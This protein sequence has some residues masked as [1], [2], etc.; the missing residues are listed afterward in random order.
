[1]QTGLRSAAGTVRLIETDTECVRLCLNGHPEV[2][3]HLVTRYERALT[4]YLF[5]RLGTEDEAVEA[6]QEAMVRAYFALSKLEKPEVF[7]PWLLGIADRVAK[8]A[9][10]KRRRIVGLDAASVRD[11]TATVAEEA[12]CT[13]E[14]LRQAVAAL[15]IPH[16][17]V[18]QMRFYADQSCAEISNN[19][20]VAVGTVTSR[21][22]RAYAMLRQSLRLHEK[23]TRVE[24]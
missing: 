9:I 21:L 19:L 2:F 20:G 1:M 22:S 18:V 11:C 16:R 8:E 15:P 14:E 23:G 5:G 17:E 6:A 3:R 10:R 13:D 12:L 4:N 24:P 7:F